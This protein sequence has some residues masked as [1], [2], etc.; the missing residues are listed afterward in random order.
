MK[1]KYFESY[2]RESFILIY[3]ININEN[4]SAIYKPTTEEVFDV[5]TSDEIWIKR[6]LTFPEIK[7]FCIIRKA[8]PLFIEPIKVIKLTEKAKAA[9]GVSEKVCPNEA[10][11]SI[12]YLSEQNSFSKFKSLQKEIYDEETQ[13]GYSLQFY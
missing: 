8:Y 7:F 5:M 11:F 12:D 10:L 2:S 6:E 4:D 1:K 9:L 3:E 13:F